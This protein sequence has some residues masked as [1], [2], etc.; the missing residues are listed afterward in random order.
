V[1]LGFCEP[2][3]DE[4]GKRVFGLKLQG[5]VVV[6]DFDIAGEGGGKNVAVFKEFRDVEII[7]ALAIEL[8]SRGEEGVKSAAPLLSSIEVWR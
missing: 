8:V 4:A 7:D 2:E 1:R 3:H 6:E 5:K